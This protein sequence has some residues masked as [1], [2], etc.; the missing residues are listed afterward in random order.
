MTYVRLPR[1]SFISVSLEE[2]VDITSPFLVSSPS[3]WNVRSWLSLFLFTRIQAPH[4]Y[5]RQDR[6]LRTTALCSALGRSKLSS[7]GFV[8]REGNEVSRRFFVQRAR[9]E[10]EQRTD[11]VGYAGPRRKFEP[12]YPRFECMLSAIKTMQ[13][14]GS[15]ESSPSYPT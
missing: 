1:L 5:R 4:P 8:A 6:Y 9:V 2:D 12:S 15:G 11:S 3:L 13:V 10:S 7:S 14:L